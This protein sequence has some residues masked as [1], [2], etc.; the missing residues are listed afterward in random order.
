MHRI[1]FALALEER[2]SIGDRLDRRCAQQL[3]LIDALNDAMA[4]F[5]V[6][7]G[8]E[9]DILDDGSLD[10]TPEMLARLIRLAHPDRHQGSEAAN[11]ATAWLL[12]QRKGAGR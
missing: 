2:R 8:I 3:D 11:I 7:K 6:L 4:P 12:A 9:V 1:H 10:Q 5:R